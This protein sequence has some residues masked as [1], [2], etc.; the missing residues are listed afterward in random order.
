MKI[1]HEVQRVRD[2]LHRKIYLSG[3]TQR[4]VSRRLG[5]GRDYVHQVL[6]GRVELK[7][8]H[9]LRIGEALG[10]EPDQLYADLVA[11]IRSQRQEDRKV[12][13]DGISWGEIRKFVGESIRMLEDRLP[14][15]SDRPPESERDD[16]P[17]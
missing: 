10:V 13:A 12:I 5:L 1:D 2:L 7:I 11:D 16:Q 14:P 4:E 9:L 17:E 8:E 3:L 15:S 6:K